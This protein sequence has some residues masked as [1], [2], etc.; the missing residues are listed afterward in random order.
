MPRSK[1][2]IA[3]PPG[4]TIKEQL[5]DRGISQKEFAVRMGLSEKHVSKLINGEVQLTPDVAVRLET[6]LGV[7]AKFW[8]KLE[9]FY[10]ED[11]IKVELENKMDADKELARLLPYAEMAKLEWVPK[12]RN[13]SEKVTHLRKYFEVIELSLLEKRNLLRIAYRKLD[14]TE[15]NDFA[16]LAWVQEARL[17]ARDIETKPVNISKLEKELKK[18]QK[19]TTLSSSVFIPKLCSLLAECGIALVFLPHL[20]GSSLQGATFLDGKKIVIALTDRNMD[21]E[22]FWLGLFHEIAHVV[23]GHVYQ[24]EC[25]SDKEEKE[26]DVWAKRMLAST[27]T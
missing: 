9:A 14:I 16:A 22:K 23:L 4:F 12:T 25:L 21:G 20:K 5:V 24:E 15:K 13:A 19:M 3:S 10:R 17:K 2:Y 27:H 18:I 11:L 1:S 26:A 8:N 6:V 7:P